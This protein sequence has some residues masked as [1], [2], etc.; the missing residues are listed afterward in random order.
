MLALAAG[1]VV[2]CSPAP[3]PTPTSTAAFASEEEAFAAAE[4]TY[5]AYNEAGNARREGKTTPDPQ[6]F[7][8]GAALEGDIDGLEY[9]RLND[10]VATGTAEVVR[11]IGESSTITHSSTEVT[12]TVCL[13]VSAARVIHESGQDVTP[14]TRPNLLAQKVSLLHTGQGFRI[15]EEFEGEV[16]SCS[17]N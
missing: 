3:K 2:G 12:A 8:V 15:S 13:D 1:L 10:L 7:L 4:E 5:R 17:P 11:F 14:A 9:L 16:A 6:D